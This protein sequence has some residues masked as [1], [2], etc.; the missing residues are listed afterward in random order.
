MMSLSEKQVA[1]LLS[2]LDRERV[3]HRDQ[4][5]L[6]LSYLEHWDIRATL[7]A[8]F[9]FGG[10]SYD[11]VETALVYEQEGVTK[12]GRPI[13]QAAYRVTLRLTIPALGATYTETAVGQA[14]ADLNNRHEA[15]D[16]AVKSASSDALKRAAINLGTQFGL[17]LYNKGS[18]QDVVGGV[19]CGA[20]D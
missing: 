7:I 16:N 15:H 20:A 19:L 18:V 13:W 5:G 1:A 9:G 10:W 2:P 12:G 14:M 11:S 4:G 8:M 6:S 17:S 3:K